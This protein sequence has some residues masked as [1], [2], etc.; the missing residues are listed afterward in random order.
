MAYVDY[1][2]ATVV[3]LA[4]LGAVAGLAW[5]R[6]WTALRAWLWRLHSGAV[7]SLPIGLRLLH[8]TSAV[9]AIAAD[10]LA[11]SLWGLGSEARLPTV[12]SGDRGVRGPVALVGDGA[13]GHADGRAAAG[14]Y[15]VALAAGVVAATGGGAV[16][17][18]RPVAAVAM[19]T[20]AANIPP[21]RVMSLA[22]PDRAPGLPDHGARGAAV[23]R[24]LDC[25]GSARASW[26]SSTVTG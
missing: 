1:V 18:Q 6:D 21:N 17:G 12:R 25:S 9:A 5:R 20:V 2:A 14:G 13:G 7:L 11:Q 15:D 23:A 10:P 22:M 26:P 8:D 16:P 4:V 24:P 19:T 3:L